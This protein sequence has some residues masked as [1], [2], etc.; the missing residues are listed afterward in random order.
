MADRPDD[1]SLVRV[2]LN[3]LVRV[4][5]EVIAKLGS[6]AFFVVLARRLGA[7]GYGEFA[8]ALALTSAL[9][10]GS[11]FGTD[12]LLARR[13]ARDRTIAGSDLANVSALKTGMSVL[14]L[15][16][17]MAVVVIGGYPGTTIAATA[18]L[19][20]GVALEVLA[21]SWHA[22]FQ[23]HERLELVSG[24]LIVQRAVMAVLGIAI[25]LSGG[26]ILGACAA[27]TVSAALGLALAELTLRR[28]TPA[29]R[30]RPSRSVTWMLLRAGFP[31]GIAGLLFV[32]LLRVDVVMLS[33]LG[34]SV[35][36]GLY[37]AGYRLVDGLQ[38]LT[39]SFGAAMLPWLARAGD[40]PRLSRTFML[41]LKLEAGALLPI[42]LVLSCFAP[43]IVRLLYGGGYA[44]AAGPLRLL[45][46][47]VA[48]YGVQSFA[49]TVL[50]ARDSA[51][52]IARSAGIVAVQNILC[53]L[54]AIPL[55]GAVGA[56]GVALSSSA[57][58][59]VLNVW[60]ASRRT[61][62]LN[63]RR[64][65]AGPMVAGI[66]MAAVALTLPIG[67]VPAGAAALIVYAAVLATLEIIIHRDDVRA[68][69]RA[70][71]A[72]LRVKLALL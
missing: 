70:L 65:F 20:V 27:Y 53:N 19:G 12:E 16:V 40:G 36:V 24:C 47:T 51:G 54:F 17:A 4:A 66:A 45:G 35:E 28:F 7:D 2:P 71:P 34:D 18:I 3:T 15:G 57:L 55:W 9:L 25:L 59:A 33:F 1:A 5:G 30:A 52:T 38:F 62:G 23:G 13:V 42:G 29:T 48:L 6:L 32:V 68:Y 58:L 26:G 63:T 21:K 44:D 37:S 41:A 46:L 61:G 43:A 39:W 50:I 10:I 8:F 67:A 22:V 60:Q 31:I 14:L 49:S 11:G 72:P 56:A 64:A 69:V